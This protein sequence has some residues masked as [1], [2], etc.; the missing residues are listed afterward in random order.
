MFMWLKIIKIFFWV[1]KTKTF[2]TDN[3]PDSKLKWDFTKF[4]SFSFRG[5]RMLSG[6]STTTRNKLVIEVALS[7]CMNYW[8]HKFELFVEGCLYNWKTQEKDLRHQNYFEIPAALNI[9]TLITL[10]RFCIQNFK[11]PL[12]IKSNNQVRLTQPF[13]WTKS[14]KKFHHKMLTLRFFFIF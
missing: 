13:D 12:H 1:I 14:E 11:L 9:N 5:K 10:K 4:F 7:S 3:F 2:L 6:I 8:F